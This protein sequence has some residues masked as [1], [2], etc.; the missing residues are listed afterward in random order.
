MSTLPVGRSSRRRDRGTVSAILRNSHKT[1]VAYF[2]TR[3]ATLTMCGFAQ[4]LADKLYE[5]KRSVTVPF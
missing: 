1:R 2:V 4:D 3:A 5:K